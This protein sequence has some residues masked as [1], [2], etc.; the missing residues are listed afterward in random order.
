MKRSRQFKAF[1]S[2]F[3]PGLITGAADDDPSGIGTYT[4]A[5]AQ[6]G[7]TFLWSAFLTWPLMAAVQM[8]CARIG[9]TSG[10]G[11][12]AALNKKLPRPLMILICLALFA[13]NV[14]NIGADLSAMG[15]GMETLHLGH[16]SIWI[17]IF[18]TSITWATIALHY[19]QIAG[20]LK[21]LALA[22]F[23]YIITVFI[24]GPDWKEVL[25]GAFTPQMPRGRDQWGMLVAIL[26]TT[27]SP[28]LFF[29]QADEEVE[30]EKSI[31]RKTVKAR[32]GATSSEIMERKFDV[33]VGTFFSNLVMFFII[34]AASLTLHK[35]GITNVQTSAEA[36][37]ALKPVAGTWA[38]ALYTIGLIGVGLLAI[39]TLTA[40]SAYAFASTFRWRIGL[41]VGWSKAKSFYLANL[42][43]IV[44]A[45][46][47]DFCGLNPIK[48]LY[49]SA[50]VNGI[51]APF[52][53]LAMFFVIRDPKIMRGQTSS[54]LGQ[55]I[56]ALT[57]ALMFTAVMVMFFE[58]QT[59][60]AAGE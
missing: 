12:A 56:V 18:A 26:G 28:Y 19:R 42:A 21:W 30:E 49:W 20:V 4:I 53:L 46:I 22:L 40:S 34:L 55:V 51:L 32:Q 37:A 9:M 17:L 44:C 33:G 15:D 27:I 41:D 43:A 6:F 11:F 47:F 25:Y 60:F 16:S 57:T 29:W 13:A 48:A 52:L 23:A 14:L 10:Q 7:G 58:V 59:K 39:P 8:A 2:A 36:A 50:L 45:L 35:Q 3:G 1:R 5:G 24:I 38:A 31:G 54:R